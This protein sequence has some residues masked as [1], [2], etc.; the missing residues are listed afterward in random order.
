M[1]SEAPWTTSSSRATACRHVFETYPPPRRSGGYKLGTSGLPSQDLDVTLA[2][3]TSG[4]LSGVNSGAGLFSYGYVTDSELLS[5][6]TGPQVSTTYAYE[7]NRDL[8]TEV[9]NQIGTTVISRYGYRSDGIARR[10]DRVKE[11]TAFS[12]GV[13]DRFAYNDRNEVTLTRNYTGTNPDG[14]SDPETVALSRQFS[15][16][17]IGNRLTSQNGTSSVRGYTSNALNQYTALT[18]PSASPVHDLDGN[19]T[20]SGSGWYYEWDAE[21][22][23]TLARDYATSPVNG[24]KKL[25]FTYDYQSRRIR[26]I[27]SSYVS[28]AWS[29][30]DDRKFIYEG[31]NLLGE[32]AT[33]GFARICAYTWGLGLSQTQQGAGGVGGLLAVTTATPSTATFFATYDG[34]G[35]VSEYISSTG[36]IEAHFEYDAFGE[37]SAST[38][39]NLGRFSH[40]FSSKYWDNTSGFYYYGFRYYITSAGRWISRDPIEEPGF[41]LLTTGKFIDGDGGLNLYRF[42]GNNGLNSYDLHGLAIETGWDVFNVAGG[43]VS[44]GCNVTSGNYLGAFADGLGLGYD[45]LATAVPGLPAGASTTLNSIR[46]A[47][48]GKALV[49]NMYQAAEAAKDTKSLFRWAI[50]EGKDAGHHIVAITARKANEARSKL[51]KLG[52]DINDFN[53]GV[54]LPVSFHQKLHTEAYYIM[55]NTA[56]RAWKTKS[57]AIA[58]LEQIAEELLKQSGKMR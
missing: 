45:V 26:K 48:A 55:I 16:D 11:G 38:G 40:R 1:T 22:R 14:P 13:Y 21:N 34:N 9:L 31:W 4:R 44:F 7:P 25:E 29:V 5:S 32:F 6:L 27:E 47:R 46:L 15:Y 2:Y 8:R 52:I 19:Q 49:R 50:R 53:N 33:S 30:L 37:I 10:K 41:I 54:A 28:S 18:N 58:G 51:N 20:Q 3:D 24:S 12:A 23:L 42:A 57:D 43:L 17:A 35:N 39:S 36:G 56:S